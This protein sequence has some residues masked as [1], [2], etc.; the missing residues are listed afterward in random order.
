MTARE[1]L[2]MH[3]AQA[4]TRADSPDVREHIRSALSEWETLPLTPL[5]KCP[6]CGRVGLPERIVYH[7]GDS[8]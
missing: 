8:E 4:L 6:V 2:R 7:D 1:R 3:L 5:V